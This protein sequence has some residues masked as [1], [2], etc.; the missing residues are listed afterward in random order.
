M[1]EDRGQRGLAIREKQRAERIWEKQ[2]AWRPSEIA[3]VI[4]PQYDSSYLRAPSCGIFDPEGRDLDFASTRGVS[5]ARGML[6][7]F[8][9][10]LSRPVIF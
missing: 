10:L 4:S 5:I 2:R 8:E 6:T 1:A 3:K 9:Q 7:I